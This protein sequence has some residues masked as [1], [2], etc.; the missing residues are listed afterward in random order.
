MIARRR[1][2]N[3]VFAIL[4]T[5]AVLGGGHAVFSFFA[6]DPPG[7]SDSTTVSIVGN[8][9]LAGSFAQ[10]YVMTYVSAEAG[11]QD[12][13]SEFIGDSRAIS[14]PKKAPK[15]S[16]PAVVFTRRTNTSG[17]LEIWSVTV[18]VRLGADSDAAVE[19]FYRVA[20]SVGS[21]RVRA[22]SLPAVVAPPGPGRD[23]VAA[24]SAPCREDTP[25]SGAA[26]G[27]LRAY[28]T[29]SADVARYTSHN[30]GIAALAPSPFDEL[31]SVSVS[32]TESSCGTSGSTAHVLVTV[33]PAIDADVLAPLD[34]PLTLVRTDQQWQVQSMDQVP[35]LPD[36]ITEVSANANQIGS[37][38]AS[39]TKPTTAPTTSVRIPPATQN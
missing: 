14:L 17:L 38:A 35:A 5:L 25:V 21:G 2:D 8:A 28:L 13:V 10:R 33:T 27:F 18:S 29:G 12:R 32:A 30:A 4:A 37:G 9:Q 1:R 3:A 7:P 31:E 11:Q 20:V 34:Y 19:Q 6:A 15:V 39:T 24:Y 36:P 23:L 26:T 22:L 16:D